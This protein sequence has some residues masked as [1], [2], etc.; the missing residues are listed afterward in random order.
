MQRYR[1]GIICC[2][3]PCYIQLRCL[4]C[5]PDKICVNSLP[6]LERVK[7]DRDAIDVQVISYYEGEKRISRNKAR[8]STNVSAPGINRMT[9]GVREA[10][11][12]RRF[13]TDTVRGMTCM[14]QNVEAGTSRNPSRKSQGIFTH[15]GDWSVVCMTLV[16]GRYIIIISFYCE[17]VNAFYSLDNTN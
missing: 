8:H 12:K 16:S 2:S 7:N 4:P 11:L 1:Y 5:I 13:V 6:N 10:S 15:T 3:K 9:N 17:H 14:V